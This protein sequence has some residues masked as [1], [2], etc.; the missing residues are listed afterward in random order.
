[1]AVAD[2]ASPFADRLPMRGVGEQRRRVQPSS[3][4]PRSCGGIDRER[5][6]L[7]W[8]VLTYPRT[9]YT[10]NCRPSARWLSDPTQTAW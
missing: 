8:Q 9:A 3:S 5:S 7:G 1:V 10:A 2:T 4:Y 6:S